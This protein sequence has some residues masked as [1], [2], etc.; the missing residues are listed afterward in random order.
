MD[1]NQIQIIDLEIPH[2]INRKIMGLLAEHHWFRAYDIKADRLKSLEQGRSLG[3][4][5]ETMDNNKLNS[6][7]D[8]YADFIFQIILKKLN[9][10]G[11]LD[12]CLWNLYFPGDFGDF[13]TDRDHESYLSVVYPLHTTDGLTIIKDQEFKDL[14]GFAKIFPSHFKHKGIGPTDS[15]FRMNLNLI[16]K[17]L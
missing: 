12:R 17:L 6:P 7:L 3:W 13:H 11:F 4:S 15:K 14:E 9:I 8:L 2:N 5:I 16:I 10:S 1:L